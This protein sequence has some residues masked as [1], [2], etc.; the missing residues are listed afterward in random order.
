ML[1]AVGP[2]WCARTGAA[3]AGN[4]PYRLV[5]PRAAAGQRRGRRP[6]DPAGAAASGVA[7]VASSAGAVRTPGRC[8]SCHRGIAAAARA[9]LAHA[10]RTPPAAQ[11]SG[12]LE[13]AAGW[14]RR[15]RRDNETTAQRQADV[16][17]A[18]VGQYGMCMRLRRAVRACVTIA[19]YVAIAT[20]RA[21]DIIAS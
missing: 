9:V 4:R 3:G 10:F 15:L 12:K 21:A 16:V 1:E 14:D 13:Q 19:R 18:Y 17:A 7:A 5:L 20:R 11:R 6:A 8:C 2:F